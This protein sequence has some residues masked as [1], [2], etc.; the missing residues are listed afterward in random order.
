VALGGLVAGGCDA[1][2]RAPD[3]IFETRDVCKY[4]RQ[5]AAGEV[6]AIHAVSLAVERGGVTVLTGPSGSG[7]S[8]LL[9]LLG[10]V[11]RATSGA[12]FFGGSDLAQCSDAERTR[13][14]RRMGLVFQNFAL[15]PRL[16]NWENITYP[17]IPR[18]VARAE[19]YELARAVASRLGIEDKLGKRPEELSGGEQQRVAI[20]RALVGTPEA[21]LADEPTSNL[22]PRSAGLFLELLM[23]LQQQGMTVLIATHDRQLIERA[24]RVIELDT[25]KI[26]G[27]P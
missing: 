15:I 17:L 7:K 5:G 2:N 4:Y 10:A 21:L 11:E 12:V 18:G 9:A 23:E 14:R 6:R 16:P 20:A 3:A 1:M 26:R 27:E 13:A 8:T 24:T 22:D 19:R 25:G